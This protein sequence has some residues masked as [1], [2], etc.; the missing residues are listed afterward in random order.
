MV[1]SS[2]IFLFL[3]LPLVLLFTLVLRDR[4]A[5]NIVLLLASLIF[6]A[7]GE[8][9]YVLTMLASI[10]MNY[11]FGR[12]IAA[13]EEDKTRNAALALGIVFNLGLLIFFKYANFI[14]G[15]IYLLLI[16]VSHF[17]LVKSINR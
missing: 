5:Q 16:W 2:P 7:W 6:Y 1:F 8:T 10:L 17:S 12:M 11:G 4:K 15:Q 9:T 14:T 3:F 13:S